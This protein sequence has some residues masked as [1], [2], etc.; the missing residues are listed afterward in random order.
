MNDKMMS[1]LTE[2]A[3]KKST[4]LLVMGDFNFPG[5]NWNT[6]ISEGPTHEQDFQ[7]GFRE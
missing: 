4:H 5:I 2:I 1:L 6:Q 7:E 3:D